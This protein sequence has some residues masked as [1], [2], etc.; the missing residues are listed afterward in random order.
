[1]KKGKQPGKRGVKSQHQ[2]NRQARRNAAAAARVR[3][4]ALRRRGGGYVHEAVHRH[5]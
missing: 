1:M 3:E 5:Q 4:S 2:L